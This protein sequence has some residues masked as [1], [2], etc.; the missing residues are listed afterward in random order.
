MD[1]INLIRHPLPATL[2]RR[3]RF[4]LLLLLPLSTVAVPVR[5][6]TVEQI[7]NPRPAGWTVDLTGSVPPGTMTELNRISDDLH[8]RTGAQMAV[9]VVGSTDG[10]D[11]RDFATRLFNSWGIGR[12]DRN[13]GVLIFAALDDRAAEVILGDGFPATQGEGTAEAIMQTEMVPRFRDGDV[14]GALLGGAQACASRLLTTVPPPAAVPSSPQTA[15]P[16][17]YDP[18]PAPLPEAAFGPGPAGPSGSRLPGAGALAILAG[19][20]GVGG[21]TIVRYRSRKCPSCKNP[22]IRLG[23]DQDDAHLTPAEATEEQIGSVDYDVWAC[24]TCDHV[25]KLRYGRLV[26]GYSDCRGCQA[27]ALSSRSVTVRDATYTE[28]GLVRIHHEC[29]HCGYHTTRTRTTPRLV[30]HDH[31]NHGHDRHSA[32][33]GSSRSSSGGGFGGGRS[34]GRG[35]SGR[36]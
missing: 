25:A 31:D 8:S 23:E 28:E 24:A 33:S 12:A 15:L 6:V 29:A 34:S 4:A 7:P 27:K 20:L 11:A 2:R 9:V 13:D 3:V 16:R 36:W 19:M 21:W 1:Q 10:A 35:A 26:S 18:A 17:A 30:R 22:M 14:A 32:W 5:A